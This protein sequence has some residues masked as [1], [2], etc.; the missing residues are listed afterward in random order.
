[1]TRKEKIFFGER[2][3]LYVLLT[4]FFFLTVID[5]PKYQLV[6]ADN[7][8]IT[9]FAANNNICLPSPIYQ[10]SQKDKSIDLLSDFSLVKIYFSPTPT[11]TYSVAVLVPTKIA[12][13]FSTPKPKAKINLSAPANLDQ[14]FDKYSV[15]YKVDKEKLKNIAHCESRFSSSAVNGIYAGLYQFSASTWQKTRKAM[16]LDQNPELR[17]NPEEAIKTAA[18][19]IANG[20]ISAW[21]ICGKK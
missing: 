1:M 10:L 21:P 7:Q 12:T 2:L 5:Y 9:M 16:G 17:F 13:I 3:W 18:F 15:E 8:P 4:I 14:L 20:G 11:P 6:N 19:K